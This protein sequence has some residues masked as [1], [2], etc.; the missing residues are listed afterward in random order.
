[1]H[2]SS[3]TSVSIMVFY[4]ILTFFIGPYLTRSF[5]DNGPDNCIAGFTVGFAISL[6]LWIKYG[7]KM[8]MK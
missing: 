2:L 3:S 5:I 1:M 6:V 8:S 7:K 4:S